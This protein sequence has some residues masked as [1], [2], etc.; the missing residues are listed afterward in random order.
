M[1][2]NVFY[3]WQLDTP[4]AENKRIIEE[5]I[6]LAIEKLKAYIDIEEAERV[7]EFAFPDVKIE[8][9]S[10]TQG[11]LGNPEIFPAILKR[12]RECDVFVADLTLTGSHKTEDKLFPN[13]N[14]C[15]EYGYAIGMAGLGKILLVMNEAYGGLEKLPFE[16]RNR[17]KP[18][19]YLTNNK[20]AFIGALKKR[21]CC[22]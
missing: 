5:C 6:N 21:L 10:D 12:I 1:G 3:S 2:M 18:V 8:V 9:Q 7:D 19:P 14:V 15:I 4:A 17:R 16:F 22:K 20:N 13:P 11:I